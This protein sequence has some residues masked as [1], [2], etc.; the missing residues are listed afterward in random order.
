MNHSTVCKVIISMQSF[1][2]ESEIEDY[3]FSFNNQVLYSCAIFNTSAF[4]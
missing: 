3:F 1:L 2:Q 4:V